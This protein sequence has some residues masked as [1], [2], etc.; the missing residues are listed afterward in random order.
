M[1]L[2]Q[3]WFHQSLHL[4]R[5]EADAAM[6]E[7][8]LVEIPPPWDREGPMTRELLVDGRI[9]GKARFHV[10]DPWHSIHLGIGKAWAA[11]GIMLLQDKLP[12]SSMDQRI[13]YIAA[14][15]KAFC[16]EHHL[17]PIL[18]RIDVSTFGGATDP[19]GSWNKAACTSNWMLFLEAFCEKHSAIV[20]GDERLRVFAS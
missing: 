5:K 19:S 13:D 15:Y 7:S 9:N 10:V 6:D 11:C 18:R 12:Q 3:I 4:L 16:K 17:D 20:Q 2:H 8:F 14:E 1:V